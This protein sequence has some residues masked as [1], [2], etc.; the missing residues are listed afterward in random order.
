MGAN[1]SAIDSSFVEILCLHFLAM[2]LMLF[3]ER[4]YMGIVIILVKIFWKI[5]EKRY[6]WEAI[7]DDVELGVRNLHWSS[8]WSILAI[9]SSPDPS[10]R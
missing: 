4:V 5:P 2:S 6:N 3:L 8:L 10:P 7:Q 1:Q 9:R